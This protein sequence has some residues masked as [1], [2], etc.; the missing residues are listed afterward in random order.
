MC[1]E[2][3]FCVVSM[4]FIYFLCLFLGV[5]NIGIPILYYLFQNRLMSRP[6]NIS[7]DKGYRPS[8]TMLVPTYNEE[9]MIELKLKNLSKLKYPKKLLEILIIDSASTDNTIDITMK[10]VNSHPELNIKILRE[11]ERLGKSKALNFGLEKAKGDVIV[12]SDSDCFLPSDTLIKAIPYLNDPTVGAVAGLEVIL[13]TEQSWIGYSEK[14]YRSFMDVIK[15]G[16]SKISSTIIF[17]GGFSAYKRKFLDKFDEDTGCDD[18]GTALN[19]VQNG[20]RTLILPDVP[21]FTFFPKKWKSKI[22]I[23]YRRAAHLIK[24]WLKCVKLMFKGDL[25]VPF[26]IIIPN[27]FLFLINPIILPFL[28]IVTIFI[29]IKYITILAP[30]LIPLFIL[31]FLVPQIRIICI[32]YVQNNIILLISM[33]A[34]LFNKDFTVWKIPEDKKNIMI[35]DILYKEKLI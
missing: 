13:N 10:F 1:R 33:L 18:S 20:A 17:E 11:K 2:I 21:F 31:A 9:K 16:Q 4:Y 27:L 19:V 3:I 34:L 8:I 15:I 26:S 30:L 22:M 5:V 6:W 7:N 28:I 14:T 23:K 32:E 35:S 29:I 12:V 24:I 25:K